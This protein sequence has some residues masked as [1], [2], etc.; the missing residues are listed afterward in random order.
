MRY[1]PLL[2]ASLTRLPHLYSGPRRIFE[3]ESAS[4]LIIMVMGRQRIDA[5]ESVRRGMT[6]FLYRGSI[7]FRTAGRSS[8]VIL[9]IINMNEST[10]IVYEMSSL[11]ERCRR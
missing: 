5:S 8:S 9:L 7:W 3:M 2:T 11:E 6:G 10:R 4:A 1:S